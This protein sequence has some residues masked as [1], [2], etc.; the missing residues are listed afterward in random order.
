MKLHSEITFKFSEI[1]SNFKVKITMAQSRSRRDN[2]GT[3][4]ARLLEAEDEDDFYKT[5]YGGFEEVGL[6]S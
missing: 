6:F 4:M 5:T 2:A 1:S 3:R